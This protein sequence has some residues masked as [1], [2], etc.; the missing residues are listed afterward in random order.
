MLDFLSLLVG[1]TVRV[2]LKISGR[3]GSAL[4]GLVVE[5]MNPKILDRVLGRLP[6]GVIIL[7]GTNGKT[8][9]T[10][11]LAALL[12]QQGLRVLTNK[13][14]SNFVRGIISVLVEYARL[15]G[16]LEYDIAVFE[17]DEAYA[18][19]LAEQIRPRGV[20]ALNVMR[21]QMDRFGEID[22]TTKMLQKLVESATDWVVLNANDE[23]VSRLKPSAGTKTLWYGHSRTLAQKFLTDDQLYESAETGYH[24]AAKP[25]TELL[26]Y[27]DGKV[28]IA[29]GGKELEYDY[30]LGGSHN[31]INLTAAL[32]ALSAA[33]PGYDDIKLQEAVRALKPAF[34]RGEV[35]TTMDGV[36]VTLQLIKNPAGFMHALRMLEVKDYGTV[37]IVINDQYADGRDVSWLWDV[38]FT[39]LGRKKYQVLCGG[40]RGDDMALRLKYDEVTAEK[41]IS[42]L[43]KFV[44]ELNRLAGSADGRVILF[45]TYTA[46][47]RLREIYK[48][49]SQEVYEVAV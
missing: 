48:Q 17:Q 37:G 9:T 25:D 11:T 42:E 38:D 27:Q 43:G 32:T 15:D 19:K 13:T 12:E 22:T 20:V 23:R 5:R 41:T 47:L 4:P 2:L 28:T 40:T 3:T 49:Y 39:L 29:A 34:G 26:A 30:A 24:L 10:K 6:N 16:R 1:K 14:G 31:A 44:P 33:V 36:Q 8:T 21:D 35:F 45:C 7:S 18:V 46:M